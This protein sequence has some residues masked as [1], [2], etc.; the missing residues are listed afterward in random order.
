MFTGIIQDLG[1]VD[2]VVDTQSGREFKFECRQLIRDIRLG[3]SICC[4]GV[5]LS[6]TEIGEHTFSCYAVKETLEKS[7]LKYLEKGS[8]VNFELAMLPV[9]R[10]G[11]HIVN[12]HVDLTVKV[13]AINNL[14]DTSIE[15]SFNIPKEFLKYCIVKGTVALNGVSLTIAKLDSDSITTALIPITLEST[16]LG[17]LKI[18]DEVNLEV[19]S[20]GKYIET[21]FKNYLNEENS[22]FLERL[23]RG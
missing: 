21:F 12:G 4:S 19:D 7:N 6:A 11:G 8:P 22:T 10:M 5:C 23:V 14:P 1:K 13:I 9:T 2:T 3:D 16:N 17:S 15:M 18:G 20:T